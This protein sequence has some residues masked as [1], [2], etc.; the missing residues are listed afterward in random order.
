MAATSPPNTSANNGQTTAIGTALGIILALVIILSIYFSKRHRA[1][2]SLQE[3]A[4]SPR[5]LNRPGLDAQAINAIP[6]VKYIN[7]G[8]TPNNCDEDLR[9]TQFPALALQTIPMEPLP[10]RR[11]GSSQRQAGKLGA[12][13]LSLLRAVISRPS[14]SPPTV[15]SLGSAEQA[16][17]CAIC[18]EDFKNGA[19]LRQLPCGHV[20]HLPC[21]DPWLK[22]FAVTCPL[23]HV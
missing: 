20:Y 6:V 1:T 8:C 4:P 3:G 15:N 21:I 23:W 18:T 11:D 13:V 10:C 9:K 7:N 2:A 14:V 17:N 16:R 5:V 22:N 19:S 12:R